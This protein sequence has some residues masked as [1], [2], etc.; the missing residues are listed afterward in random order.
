[1][2]TNSIDAYYRTLGVSSKGRANM[3][4]KRLSIQN[5]RHSGYYIYQ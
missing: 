3:A 2:T 5:V 4:T 1:M